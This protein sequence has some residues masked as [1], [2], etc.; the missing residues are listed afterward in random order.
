ME[1]QYRIA[2]IIRIITVAPLMALILLTSLF[3][4]L[5]EELGGIHFYLISVICLTVLPLIGYPLQ[6]FLPYFKSRGRD[7]QRTLAIIM[8]VLGY[9]CS[10][11]YAAVF[12]APKMVWVVYLLYLLSGIGIMFFNKVLKVRASGHACGVVGPVLLASYYLGKKVFALAIFLIAIVFWSS[13]KMKRHTKS[14]LFWGSMIPLGMFGL[15][16]LITNMIIF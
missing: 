3:F 13:L 10:I 5:P 8:A 2:K 12:Q 6:P 14:Q 9:F 16:I 15:A 1:K 11:I 7:G 4:V